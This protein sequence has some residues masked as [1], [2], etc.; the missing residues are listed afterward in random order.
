MPI[1][2]RAGMV[3]LS[4]SV[5]LA[6]A[7]SSSGLIARGQNKNG[8]RGIIFTHWPTN[9]QLAKWAHFLVGI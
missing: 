1:H 5:V 4:P 7:H 2:S 6:G 9:V 8:S 3:F